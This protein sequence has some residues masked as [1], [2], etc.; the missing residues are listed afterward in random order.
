MA[1]LKSTILEIV[2]DETKANEVVSKLGDF[3]I[4]KDQY[5]KKVQELTTIKTER[6]S[7][8]EQF[9]KARVEKMSADEKFK[10][11]FEKLEMTKKD[12]AK[13]SN[14]LEVKSMFTSKGINVDEYM[15]TIESIVSHD[16]ETTKKVASGFLDMIVK[17]KEMSV[18]QTKEAVVNGTPKPNTTSSVESKTFVKKPVY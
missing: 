11:E 4:P 15:E 2:G 17:Q 16:E 10:H 6:D 13:K 7:F 14:L 3:M 1:D 5:N 8:A 9:E 12:F 18:Q